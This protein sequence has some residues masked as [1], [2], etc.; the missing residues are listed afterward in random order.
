M[1]PEQNLNLRL[2]PD[3]IKEVPATTV[4]SNSLQKENNTTIGDV[5]T[6]M[7][8]FAQTKNMEHEFNRGFNR[9]CPSTFNSVAYIKNLNLILKGTTAA[10]IDP[11]DSRSI[12]LLTNFFKAQHVLVDLLNNIEFSS[13]KKAVLLDIIG[14]T[15]KYFNETY[16]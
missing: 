7:R 10:G 4:R 15:L 3:P 1:N 5:I 13:D 6:V 9:N 16:D 11:D 8:K 14:Y 2:G 12:S